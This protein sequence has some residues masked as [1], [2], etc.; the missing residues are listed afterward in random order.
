MMQQHAL[1]AHN[2]SYY[3]AARNT[4]K[5]QA[6]ILL[7]THHMC[8]FAMNIMLCC[9][10]GN[11]RPTMQCYLTYERFVG[12]LITRGFGVTLDVIELLS[13]W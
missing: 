4:H 1:H 6:D 5:A 13:V 3:T 7:R 8:K 12:G 2:A 10:A 9:V 11:T